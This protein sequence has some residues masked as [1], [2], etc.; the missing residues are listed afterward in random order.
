MTRPALDAP[1][2]RWRLAPFSAL[3][4][5][6]LYAALALRQRVFVVEQQCAYLD[7]DGRDARAWHLFGYAQ[8]DAPDDAS[9][10]AYARIFAPEHEAEAT[11]IGRVVN[12][13]EVRGQ[14]I[15]RALMS[16]ALRSAEAIAPGAPVL[17]AAQAYLERFYS[18]FGFVTIS[19]PYL[20]DGIPH[21]DMVRKGG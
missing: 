16:E 21:V 8:G 7:A 14:G 4:A 10:L 11:V 6:E 2:I 1:A 5:A 20:E 17:L 9:L 12:A 3:S 13:P 19:E 15:G 18:S